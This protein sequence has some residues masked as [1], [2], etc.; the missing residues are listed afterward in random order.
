MDNEEVKQLLEARQEP[1]IKVI[2]GQRGSYGWEIK[3]LNL[4]TTEIKRLDDE[5]RVRFLE[6]A[7]TKEELIK[8]DLKDE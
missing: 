7:P 3:I 8:E 5:M 2:R 6:E 4:N 1:S